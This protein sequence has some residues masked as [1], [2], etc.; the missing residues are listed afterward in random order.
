MTL[1]TWALEKAREITS[2]IDADWTWDSQTLGHA[3]REEAITAIATA[4]REARAMGPEWQPIETAPRDGTLIII[5]HRPMDSA[6]NHLPYEL[7]IAAWRPAWGLPGEPAEWIGIGPRGTDGDRTA[8][9]LE[10]HENF[11]AHFPNTGPTHWQ[12][13]PAPPKES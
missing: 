6:H 7:V 12:P 10:L 2:D 13:L 8:S 11:R 3:S 5:A 1:P 9:K 4:L